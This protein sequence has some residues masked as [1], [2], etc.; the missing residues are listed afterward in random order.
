[1]PIPL[2]TDFPHGEDFDFNINDIN[3]NDFESNY[4]Q[5]YLDSSDLDSVDMNKHSFNNT[6][7]KELENS[8][9]NNLIYDDNKYDNSLILSYLNNDSHVHKNTSYNYVLHDRNASHADSHKLDNY[10][11]VI[12]Y[13]TKN[14]A[15]I[16]DEVIKNK[17]LNIDLYKSENICI[18]KCNQN[19]Q[20]IDNCKIKK[21]D[22]CIDKCINYKS[23]LSCDTSSKCIAAEI[24]LNNGLLTCNHKIQDIKSHPNTSTFQLELDEKKVSFLVNKNLNSILSRN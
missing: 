14:P 4:N 6:Q 8:E 13:T 16:Q 21:I 5:N 9:Y 20:C 19:H 17:A 3:F 2:Y 23:D 12:G 18:E 10:S 11:T 1:M 15:P 7:S 22:L 24:E